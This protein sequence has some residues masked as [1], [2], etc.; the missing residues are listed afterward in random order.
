[1]HKIVIWFSLV[2]KFSGAK[3][4]TILV[5]SIQK[6]FDIH[7]LHKEGKNNAE[8][9]LDFRSFLMRFFYPVHVVQVSKQYPWKKP[10]H[11]EQSENCLLC[12]KKYFIKFLSNFSSI[13][14]IRFYEVKNTRM[15][16]FFW[17][18]KHK[19]LDFAMFSK[20]MEKFWDIIFG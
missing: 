17:S 9:S 6:L 3:V 2:S 20:N 14:T 15:K 4:I 16:I 18:K 19:F 13:W 5:F 8:S 7:L 1:M 11:L 12:V 10:K